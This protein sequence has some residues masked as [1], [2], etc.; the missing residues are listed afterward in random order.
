MLKVILFPGSR[1]WRWRCCVTRGFLDKA[2]TWWGWRPP[3]TEQLQSGSCQV[4]GAENLSYPSSCISCRLIMLHLKYQIWI[5][6]NPAAIDFD[7]SGQALISPGRQPSPACQGDYKLASFH[8]KTM[9][10]NP[11]A[12]LPSVCVPDFSKPSW[13]SQWME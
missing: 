1:A 5:G 4:L 11:C 3:C 10:T 7:F 6:K 2:R 12:Q 9:T 8:Q 13:S